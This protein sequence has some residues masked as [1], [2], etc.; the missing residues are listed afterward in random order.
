MK[1]ASMAAAIGLL[2]LATAACGANTTGQQ[3]GAAKDKKNLTVGFANQTLSVTFPAAVQR[4]VQDEAKRLGVKLIATNAEDNDPAKQANNV[5]DL[6][7]QQ[8]D[9]I[10]I[11]PVSAAQ[12]VRLVRDITDAGIPVAGVHG[13]ISTRNKPDDVPPKMLFI[14]NEDEVA[15]GAEAGKLAVKALP[16]GGKVA[17]IEGQAG[18]AEVQLRAQDFRTALKKAGNF[19]VVASQPGDWT[20]EKGQSACSGVL[21]AHPDLS[22]VY[23]ESDDM[24][25]GC[26]KAAEAV[27]SKAKIIGV[28]GA[29]VGITGIE[30]GSIYGTICYKPYDAGVN[31]MKRLYENLRGKRHDKGA[32]T[33]YQSPAITKANV[34]QCKPQW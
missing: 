29:K 2:A 20:L 21:S 23:A 6:I 26:A 34:G 11:S 5:Q 18:F 1:R 8:P 24:A 28:G 19:Q 31:A 13:T 10:L 32:F 3:A 25:A 33:P 17:I 22:L 15:A 30:N 16:K 4:G 9:A 7:A 12:S 14:Y 27:H